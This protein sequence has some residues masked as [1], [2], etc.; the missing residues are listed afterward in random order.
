[1][2]IISLLIILK[3]PVFEKYVSQGSLGK[4]NQ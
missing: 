3:N 1:M 4:Q 2:R